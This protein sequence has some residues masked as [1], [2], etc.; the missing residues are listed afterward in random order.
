MF[1]ITYMM[2]IKLQTSLLNKDMIYIF[3]IK[4][5]NIRIDHKYLNYQN[6]LNKQNFFIKSKI[7]KVV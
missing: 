3:L 1:K 2:K 7:I 4:Q 6:L 5:N